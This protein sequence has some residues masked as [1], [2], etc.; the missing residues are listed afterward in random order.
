MIRPAAVSVFLGVAGIAAGMTLPALAQNYS[1]SDVRIEGNDRVDATTILGFARINRGQAISA[2]ELNEAYQRLADSGLFETVEI[3]PQ[4][5]TLVIRVQEFPTI[6]IINFEGNARIKDDKLAGLVKSQSRRAYNPAQAE[7]DAAAITEAYRVQGR[8]AA[9][10]T[11]KI[12]RRSDNRVDLVFDIAEGKVVEIERLSF[13]GNRAYSD[14]RLRQVLETKQAG[15]L[16]SIIASDT[17]IAERVE[18]DKQL[19]RDFYLSRGF[20]DFE[21]LDATAEVTRERDAFFMTFTVQEGQSY[22][23]GQITASSEVEGIDAADFQQAL[24]IRRGVTYSPSVVENNIARLES[25]ALQKG[26]NFVRIEPRITRNERN[27]TLD[28]NFALVRGERIF[29]ERIDIEGNT[30]TL[31]QVVRRQFRTVEGDPFNPREVRQSAERIRALGYFANADVNTRPGSSPDQVVVDVNVEE[32]PTG[33]LSFG[34]SYGVSSGVG[35]SIGFSEQNFL[36]RGQILGVDVSTGTDNVNTQLNFVEPSFLGRDL[37]FRFNAYYRE[38]DN[39]YSRYDTRKI[40]IS[41]SIEFPVSDSGR[42]ELRYTLSEDKISN[43]DGGPNDTDDDDDVSSIILINEEARGALI[44]SSVGYTYSWDSNRG[45]LNPTGRNLLR[46]SQD[47]AGVGGDVE[48]VSTTALAMAER[49]VWNEEVTVRAII[50]GGALS[51]IGDD[52]S[53]VTDRFFGNGKIRGFEPNGIGPR[54][55]NVSNEDALGGN[56]FA[57]ARLEADFPLGLPEEY[58]FSGGVFADAGSVWSLDDVGGGTTGD[59]PVDDDFHIRSSVGV[60]LFWTTPI[61]P[62]RFN[63]AKAIEK[64]DYDKEQFFDLTISTRF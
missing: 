28:V 40:G 10:V 23:F 14:R 19:L 7:A 59:D 13:V 50:E 45:G 60:S 21:V 37:R 52:P 42:L 63:F 39:Q 8:I 64:Q 9:T 22:S 5:G 26:L 16:R 32:Q 20:I 38:T 41:P 3:V 48:Y 12:I 29:V 18:L 6:N 53:R 27:Q 44:A 15:L 58:G 54:D 46:F 4:G 2:G 31:D 35:F 56:Y 34:V 57:V 55:L 25:L 61:G 47:F 62:L 17:F 36:G 51:M 1:F 43:V 49:K 33:S 11:P 24:R 30:T